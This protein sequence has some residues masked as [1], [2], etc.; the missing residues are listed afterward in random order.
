MSP[1]SGTLAGPE[2]HA[3]RAKHVGGSEIASLFYQWSLP[4][5]GKVVYLHMFEKPPEGA[6]NLGCVSRHTTGFRL[7]HE[8]AGKMEKD[9][10]EGERIDAGIHLEPALATW[11]QAKWGPWPL[12]K[13]TEYF[14]HPTVKGLGVS[15]DYE[16]AKTAVPVEFKNVDFLIF[17]DGWSVDPSDKDEITAPPMDI[18]LQV[19]HQMAGR[20]CKHG[21]IVACVGGNNLKRGLILRH[22]PTIQKIE[23]AVTAF[24]QAIKDGVLPYD[25]ADFDTIADLY[26]NGSKAK[27]IDLRGDN[28]APE[29]CARYLAAK[30]AK[31]LAE[32]TFDHLKAQLTAKMGEATRAR[33]GGYTLSWVAVHREEKMVPAKMQTALDYRG[34]F[35]VTAA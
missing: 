5:D 32:G 35:K 13:T 21:W 11:A 6:I 33:V 23:T 20:T 29:L 28:E 15:R 26:G 17:R 25:I 27:E 1:D 34:A 24:W 18:T 9:P 10:V 30:T 16:E 2:W 8:K 19:Q 4:P 12:V 7:Y 3:L 31:D 22:D 14:S